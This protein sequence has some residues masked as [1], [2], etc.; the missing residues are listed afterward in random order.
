M[1]KPPTLLMQEIAV[2]AILTKEEWETMP[3][4]LFDQAS[5]HIPLFELNNIIFGICNYRIMFLTI[6]LTEH[7]DVSLQGTQSETLTVCR[8]ALLHCLSVETF[9]KFIMLK[10]SPNSSSP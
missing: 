2:N 6:S 9:I 1:S 7:P 10:P 4:G 3:G 5:C 8:P